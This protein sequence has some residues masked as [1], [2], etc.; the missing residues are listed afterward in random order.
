MLRL[1][2]IYR[3]LLLIFIAAIPFF[4]FPKEATAATATRYWRMGLKEIVNDLNITEEKA[5]EGQTDIS[6][7]PHS[8]FI[9]NVQV[10]AI[11]SLLVCLPDDNNCNPQQTAL[12]NISTVI[13]SIYANPPASF[14]YY[15]RDYLANAGFIK[16]VFAQGIG[17]AAMTPLLSLWKTSRNI[18]YAILIIVMVAIGFM[19]IFRMKID[20]KTVISLQAALPKIILTLVLITLSY[21]IVGFLIDMM[22]LVMA[23]LIS[24][25]AQGMGGGFASKVAELQSQ[26][27]TGGLGTLAGS[28]FSGGFRSVDDFIKGYGGQLGG[29]SVV[30]GLISMIPGL[31]TIGLGTAAVAAAPSA[32]IILILALGLLF[33]F[34]RLVL[35]L[36]NSYIQV[37]ISLI[38][39]PI[40][41]L[42]EA[43][44]GK[45]A[46]TDWILNVIANLV[47]F[48][49]TAA[50][51]MFAM[52]LTSQ[53]PENTA[54]QPPLLGIGTPPVFSAFIGIGVLFMAP[55][56]IASIKKMFAPKP[57]LPVSP[58]TIMAPLT[59]SFQTAMG[60]ASQFYYMG[61][62]KMMASGI[63]G[64]GDKGTHK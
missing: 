12:G 24:V 11:T 3:F 15:A 4:S 46:F 21:P 2:K 30:I 62:L 38:I 13:A 45:S 34:I 53:N 17:F 19:I 57:A 9:A 10:A 50:V 36:V 52:F 44:P 56:L 58:G 47:V 29:I 39:G 43:V 59:G 33:T 51:L 55:T 23:I 48:P 7:V 49:A 18:A 42:A 25:M 54:W 41:L 35:L 63:F 1:P 31:V 27:M 61:Q 14:A 32:I 60:A 28:V 6:A 8:I 20:P 16:P 64:G 22:Y 37:M 40:Q 5:K 26:Y